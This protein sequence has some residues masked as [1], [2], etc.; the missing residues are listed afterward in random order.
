MAYV[1]IPN[2]DVDAESPI[3]ESL[4][5][6]MRDNPIAIANADAGTD[7]PPRVLCNASGATGIASTDGTEGQVLQV[8]NEVNPGTGQSGLMVR[9]VTAVGQVVH[10]TNSTQGGGAANLTCTV[11]LS[12]DTTGKWAV[13]VSGGTNNSD[14]SSASTLGVAFLGGGAVFDSDSISSSSVIVAD[15]F[16]NIYVNS[17][18]S[19][20]R[21]SAGVL[22]VRLSDDPATTVTLDRD[23]MVSAVA[24]RL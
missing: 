7:E 14:S 10:G 23:L 3:T 15:P 9:P 5:T 16:Q 17:S 21:P 24:I 6:Q 20:T 12:L 18:V 1:I 8:V 2:T 11:D 19:V 22:R 13:T 4:M